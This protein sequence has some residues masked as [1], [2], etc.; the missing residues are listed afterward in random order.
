[1]YA[2]HTLWSIDCYCLYIFNSQCWLVNS[3]KLVILILNVDNRV[4]NV[5]ISTR[6]KTDTSE[7]KFSNTDLGALYGPVIPHNAAG[8]GAQYSRESI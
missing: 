5:F 4:L 1:M 7:F 2:Y 8:L 6:S 3:V